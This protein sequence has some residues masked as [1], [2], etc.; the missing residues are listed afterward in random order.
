MCEKK[1]HITIKR[2]SM[3]LSCSLSVKGIKVNVMNNI[4]EIRYRMKKVFLRLHSTNVLITYVLSD[5][6]HLDDEDGKNLHNF[7]IL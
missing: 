5:T 7:P 4:K 3:G 2:I 6:H 1:G